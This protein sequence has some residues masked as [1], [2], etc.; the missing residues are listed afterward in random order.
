MYVVKQRCELVVL[1]HLSQQI[2][3]NENVFRLII[4]KKPKVSSWRVL[5]GIRTKFSSWTSVLIE[6]ADKPLMGTWWKWLAA[7]VLYKNYLNI[8]SILSMVQWLKHLTVDLEVNSSSL[9]RVKYLILW[10]FLSSNI[11]KYGNLNC[12]HLDIKH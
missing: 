9:K 7:F 10:K 5:Y 2:N 11:T 4:S 12:Q 6:S 3:Y 1:I 8:T